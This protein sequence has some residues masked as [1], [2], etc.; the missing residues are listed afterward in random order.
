MRERRLSEEEWIEAFQPEEDA[1]GGLYVQRDWTEADDLKV[2][3]QARVERRLWT[4]VEGD[5]GNIGILQGYHR[6]NRLYYII[7][8]VSHAEDEA[9]EVEVEAVFCAECGEFFASVNPDG[10]EQGEGGL[11]VECEAEQ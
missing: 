10:V 5:G 1:H 9:I 11:C 8:A 6:V 3:E 7:C 2:I 4:A